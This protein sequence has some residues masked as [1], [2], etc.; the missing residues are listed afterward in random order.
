MRQ[1]KLSQVTI[2]ND[3]LYNTVSWI[4]T[5][6]I[7]YCWYK[8][9][10]AVQHTEIEKLRSELEIALSK[11]SSTERECDSL[12]IERNRL[13]DELQSQTAELEAAKAGSSVGAGSSG[14]AGLSG[15][16]SNLGNIYDE[17]AAENTVPSLKE[18][19]LT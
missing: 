11:R 9:A 10:S 12:R 15:S 13:E 16:S 6:S 14:S 2:D 19:V 7:I 1:R 18:K 8:S 3:A 4:G 17:S 5:N